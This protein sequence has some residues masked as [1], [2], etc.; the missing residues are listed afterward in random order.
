M[1]TTVDHSIE[2]VAG[3]SL[4]EAGE[5]AQGAGVRMTKTGPSANGLSLPLL[6]ELAV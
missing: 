2:A 3:V 1:S 5:G 4:A 6:D